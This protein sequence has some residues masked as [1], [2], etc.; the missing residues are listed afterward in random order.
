MGIGPNAEVRVKCRSHLKVYFI[1][2]L[3]RNG[4]VKEPL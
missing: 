2:I 1:I 3:K 4:M